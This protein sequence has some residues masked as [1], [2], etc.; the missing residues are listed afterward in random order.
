[1]RIGALATDIRI[2]TADGATSD[3]AVS[4]VTVTVVGRSAAPA[5]GFG[6]A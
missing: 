2:V 1:V 4:S 3:I 5:A 6:G